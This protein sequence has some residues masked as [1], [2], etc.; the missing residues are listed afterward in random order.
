MQR[1]KET[2][3]KSLCSKNISL[4]KS[5][6]FDYDVCSYVSRQQDWMLVTTGNGNGVSW[7]SSDTT[8]LIDAIFV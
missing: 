6:C 2:A 3:I 5:T 8:G 1:S 4:E 7:Y